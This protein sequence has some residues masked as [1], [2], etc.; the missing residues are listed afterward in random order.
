MPYRRSIVDKWK[1]K[2]QTNGAVDILDFN[3][4]RYFGVPTLSKIKS[5]NCS[6]LHRNELI[7]KCL[8]IVEELSKETRRSYF[9]ILTKYVSN[10]D[11]SKVVAFSKDSVNSWINVLSC[12]VRDKRLNIRTAKHQLST[13]HS[14]MD[15][16]DLPTKDW[17]PQEP[18][19]RIVDANSNVEPY[20]NTELKKLLRVLTLL[21]TALYNKIKKLYVN[22]NFHGNT[23]EVEIILK[24]KNESDKHILKCRGFVSKYY[25]TSFYLLVYFTTQNPTQIY[26]MK[27][28]EKLSN[29]EWY[30]DLQIKNRANKWISIE[31]GDNNNIN[32][33]KYA[34]TF[35]RKLIEITN[36][37]APNETRL[38]HRVKLGNKL[39]FEKINGRNLTGY[40]GGFGGW[41]KKEFK[42]LD[43]NNKLL[44][45]TAQRLRATANSLLIYSGLSDLERSTV[46]NNTV[47]V[48]RRSYSSGNEK[49]K[50]N[51]L[52]QTAMVAENFSRSGDITVSKKIVTEAFN[53]EILSHELFLQRYSSGEKSVIGT[54]CK[55]PSSK[56]QA[57]KY[58][59]R[60][61]KEGLSSPNEWIVCG[62]HLCFG[63]E[64]QV[65]IEDIEH[66]WCLL[67][68]RNY[69]E[70]KKCEHQDSF[71]FIRNYGGLLKN[72]ESIINR[73]T[74]DIK[75][76]AEIKIKN[77]GLHPSW[78][79]EGDI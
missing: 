24:P 35:I 10:C 32:I 73:I 59:K 14:F 13:I 51:N 33:E 46:L 58:N 5:C 7:E 63:C 19:F 15:K 39:V 30:K 74:P 31:L 41:F 3:R 54:G 42:I 12:Q 62:S 72:I 44:S 66:I 60:L 43:D 57:D 56:K 76:K 52:I 53:I 25:Y 9:S 21:N 4:L 79:Y 18:T 70:F 20:S 26:N 55:N 48:N 6:E 68:Y 36:L 23:Q 22:G 45:P 28:P 38:L 71:H 78:N 50:K 67:S 65:I 69:I 49:D 11:K 40:K 34:L 64:N 75:R 37:I 29:N 77:E 17:F 61:R 8:S 1:I 2:G 47:S 27:I 16:M